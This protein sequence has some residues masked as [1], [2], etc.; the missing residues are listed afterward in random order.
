MTSQH[1]HCRCRL[2]PARNIICCS[3]KQHQSRLWIITAVLAFFEGLFG[4]GGGVLKG[5]ALG[6]RRWSMYDRIG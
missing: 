1:I 5:G 4:G 2:L 6:G 3:F